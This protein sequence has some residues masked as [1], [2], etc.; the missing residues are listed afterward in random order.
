METVSSVKKMPLWPLITATV[1]AGIMGYLY[2]FFPY[3]SGYGAVRV[4]LIVSMR[5]LWSEPDWT[6]GI[7]VPFM[8]IALVIYKRKELFQQA[9]DGSWLGL[10]V[11]LAGFFIYWIGY[12]ANVYYFAFGAGQILLGGIIIWFLGREYFW[13]L[14]FVWCFF[15]FTW[16][17]NAVAEELRIAYAL[18]VVMVELSSSFL[19]LIGLDNVVMGTSIQ[20]AP[21]FEEGIAQGAKYKLDVADPCS[22]IRS[23]FALMM[24][25]ALW[26]YLTLEKPWQRWVLFFSAPFLAVFG[27]FIRIMLLVVGSLAFGTEFAVGEEGG[28]SKYHFIAGIFVFIAALSLMVV[29]SHFLKSGPKIFR[30]AQVVRTVRVGQAGG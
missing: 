5:H 29:L 17:L 23:L 21:V 3:A 19:N 22:G 30:R 20:S 24:V 14:F 11:L 28:T 1:I 12:K 13:R 2:F 26:G 8:V 6:H 27:N 7:L 16:P 25:T 18:R 15:S 9:P 10:P 4:P